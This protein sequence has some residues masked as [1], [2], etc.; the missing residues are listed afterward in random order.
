MTVEHLLYAVGLVLLIG[1]FNVANLLLAR[2]DG[3]ARDLA[4]RAALGAGRT[5]L[6][7]MLLVEAGLI[8]VLGGAAGIGLAY[9]LVALIARWA[10]QTLP[11]STAAID[12]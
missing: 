9:W 11:A 8:G 12:A 1:C 6:T 4:V 5:R 7:R 3:R 2:G 10:P